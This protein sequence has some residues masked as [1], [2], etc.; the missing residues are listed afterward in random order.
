[1]VRNTVNGKS[2]VISGKDLPSLLNRHLAQLRLNAHMVKQLQADWNAQKGEAFA[3]EIVD[4]LEPRDE[5]GY[6]PRKDLEALEELWLEKLGSYEPAG[7][8]RRPK[9]DSP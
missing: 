8:N 6:D 9:A 2:L 1:V 7:Y 4:T 5:P 3:F